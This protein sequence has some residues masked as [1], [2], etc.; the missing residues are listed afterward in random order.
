MNKVWWYVGGIVVGTAVLIYA[1]IT[2]VSS[3]YPPATDLR[4]AYETPK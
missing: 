2:T 3:T 1:V 4:A